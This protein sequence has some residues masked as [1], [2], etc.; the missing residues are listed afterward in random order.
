MNTHLNLATKSM[1]VEIWSD[2]MCPFCYIGKRRFEEAL[3]QFP[4]KETITVIWKSFQLDPNTPSG[5]SRQYVEY[6]AQH[7]GMPMQQVS[8]MIAHVTDMARQTGLDFHFENAIVAN[9]FDAHRLLHW[10]LTQGRQNEVKELLLA[11]H[12]SE[13]KDI[14]DRPTLVNIA[15]T[16]GLD[17][18]EAN[19]ML[20][21]D[22]NADEVRHD[23]REASQIGVQGVPFFVF[24]R[25]YAVSGA[26]NSSAFADVLQQSFSEWQS[27]QAPDDALQT[28]SQTAS[29]TLSGQACT[30]EGV[31]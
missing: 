26:Q 12:F 23:I 17:A 22:T 5:N 20:E 21:S 15:V 2:V 13:G 16:A 31:C 25:R 19:S 10:A 29:Q 24:N 4:H 3:E 18:Q 6:L 1:T 9:S 27:E 7:K 14:S 30:P 11:A 8:A 28:S